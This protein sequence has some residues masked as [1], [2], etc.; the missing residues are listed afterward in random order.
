L[1]LLLDEHFSRRVAVELRRRGYDVAA[2]SESEHLRGWADA[3]LF[4]HACRERRAIVTQDFRGFRALVRDAVVDE[5]EHF[6]VIFVPKTVWS[7]LGD[8][9][10]FVEALERFL[11]ERPAEDAL[12]NGVAW[13]EG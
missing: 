8:L 2:V 5:A 7:S 6:G 4:A 12:L 11:E 3:E 13:V 9:E 1:R 10:G